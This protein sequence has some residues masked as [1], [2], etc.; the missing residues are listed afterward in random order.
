MLNMVGGS[1][2]TSRS[3][4]VYSQVMCTYI[5][6]Q[7]EIDSV[8]LMKDK[9]SSEN[10]EVWNIN[11]LSWDQ[12]FKLYIIDLYTHYSESLCLLMLQFTS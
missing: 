3:L 10:S 11:S 12:K 6:S 5:K 9:G 8:S 7:P 1:Y 4:Q 2:K